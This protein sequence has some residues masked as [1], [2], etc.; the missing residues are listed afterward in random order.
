MNTAAS[1]SVRF[2]HCQVGLKC[3]RSQNLNTIYNMDPNP[4]TPEDLTGQVYQFAANLL[5]TQKQTSDQAVQSL[6]AEGID[7]ESATTVVFSVQEEIKKA[8]RER[9]N[10]DMLYGALWCMGGL[11]ATLADIGFIFWGAILF[12]GIQFFKGVANL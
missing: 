7:K 9:A 2:A 5:V 12:G 4:T 10:K 1:R 8:K 6:V 11:I 3:R